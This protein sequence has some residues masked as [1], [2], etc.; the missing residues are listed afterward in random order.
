V[1]YNP[2]RLTAGIYTITVAVA[3]D[4]NYNSAR[5]TATLTVA[6]QAT[7]SITWATPA[8]IR[9]GTALSSTQLDAT[10]SVP[11]SFAYSPAS[12]TLTAG[13]HA[14]SVTFTS[15]DTIDYTT[16][17][18]SVTLQVNQATPTVTA[19]TPTPIPFGTAS[20]TV[21]ATVGYPGPNA[22]TGTVSFTVANGSA[23]TASC[24]GSSSPI[25]CTASYATSA[26]A[27]GAHTLTASLTANSNYTAASATATLTVTTVATTL[28]LTPS[29][30][31]SNFFQ[32]VTL[33]ASLSPYT[34]QGVS[35]NGETITFMNGSK[36]LGTAT[37]S[38]GTAS[39]KVSNLPFGTD[40]LSAIYAGDSDFKA[41]TATATETVK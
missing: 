38:G 39:I 6:T 10:A 30:A 40:K 17:T 28:V 4:S 3:A 21:T 26:L 24:S 12:G 35:T 29:P 13:A 9:Y 18:A 37:L 22:P 36:K 20:T 14:L 15:T 25:T 8:A 7:P 33:K 2:S 19:V 1:S 5:A 34:V 41:A 23:V 27:V 32:S 16:A 11:G 31:S